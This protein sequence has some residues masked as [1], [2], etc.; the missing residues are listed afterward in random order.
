MRQRTIAIVGGVAGG[1]SAAAR[2]RRLDEDVEIVLI[3][4]GEYISFANCGLPYHIGG[5]IADREDLLVQS[6]EGMR[7]RFRIDVR[8]LQEVRRIDRARKILVVRDLERKL[9]Y[10]Q[11]YDALILSP[12]AAPVRPPLPGIDLPGVYT[13]R[14]MADMDAI[15]AVVDAKPYGRA[16]ILGGGYIGLELAEA[17]RK[18]AWDVMIVELGAQVMAPA[19]PEMAALLHRELRAHGVDLRLRT[20]LKGL[21]QNSQGRLQAEVGELQEDVDLVVLAVGV[22]PETRLAAEAG[23][24]LGPKGGIH[25]DASMRTSDPDIF[26]VGDAVE[27]KD[28]V[29]GTEALIPLAGPA[30]R[31]GRIAADNLCGLESRYKGTQGTAIARVFGSVIGMTGA[32]EKSLRSA[33]RKFEKV[34]LHPNC[35]AGYYPG[36]A[37]LQVKLLFDPEDGRLLGG[38]AVGSEGV[39][40]RIDVLAVALRAGLT[41]YELE[42]LE[43]AYAPPFGSAK[44]PVNFAGFVAANVLEGKAPL[45]HA[46]DFENP[47]PDQVIVDVRSS[48]EFEAG[49]IPGAIHVPLDSLRERLQILPKD[50]ELLLYCRV[51]LRGYLAQ[52]I[53]LQR[54]YR[55]RNLSGGML[56]WEAWRESQLDAGRVFQQA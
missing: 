2:L 46:E 21:R 55:A 17:L 22:R 34:Y 19:D 54:G 16:L 47:R 13:L 23:L 51:G 41:V 52:R 53:L 42:E 28:L 40:K 18:R 31:Q 43:L 56:T 14:N 24:E 45:A 3:E 44:D 39:D 36:A 29:I 1:A 20:A 38:Q 49:H 26:A 8:T 25:V 11:A 50:K 9:D 4:K 15:K 37:P 35:H 27:V 32:S 5:D 48:T 10:E 30:N 12:G 7:R 6:A 33:G